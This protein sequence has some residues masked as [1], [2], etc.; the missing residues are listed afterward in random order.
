[1]NTCQAIVKPD[2]SKPKVQKSSG[3]KTALKAA[4]VSCVGVLG[5]DSFDR[6]IQLDTQKIPESLS[7]VV[8]CVTVE[9]AG[10]KFKTPSNL[11]GFQY[12]KFIE[13]AVFQKYCLIF[14]VSKT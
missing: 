9:F 12:I 2:C 6:L 11:T 7:H 8:T 4:F 13:K 1:M 5:S 10:V 14:H 3:V